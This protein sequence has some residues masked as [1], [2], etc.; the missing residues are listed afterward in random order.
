M[1]RGKGKPLTPPTH[2]VVNHVIDRDA[3]FRGVFFAGILAGE[4]IVI[5]YGYV[6]RRRRWTKGRRSLRQGLVRTLRVLVAACFVPS[7]VS[8]I[9]VT[10]LDG[11]APGFGFRCAGV[12]GLLLWLG[13]RIVGTVPISR[14]SLAWQPTA[15]PTE[16]RTRLDRAERFH[17]VGAWAAVL[18]FASFLAALDAPRR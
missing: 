10:L 13:V 15:P 7:A 2:S 1:L 6:D 8:G 12:M 18:V 9:A 4:E 5:H 16:W 17:I 3:A 14:A 11:V